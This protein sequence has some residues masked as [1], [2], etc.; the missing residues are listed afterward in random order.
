MAAVFAGPLKSFLSELLQI[1][2]SRITIFSFS[3]AR[4]L[5]G[6][7]RRLMANLAVEYSVQVENSKVEEVL[8]EI[9]SGNATRRWVVV[10]WGISV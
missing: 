5:R 7:L 3:L 9:V 8:T 1:D 6:N 10:D 4:R 2:V